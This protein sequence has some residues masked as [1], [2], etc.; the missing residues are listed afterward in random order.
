MN[1]FQKIVG[2]ILLL[3][4]I[5]SFIEQYNPTSP[6]INGLTNSVAAKKLDKQHEIQKVEEVLSDVKTKLK[7][8]MS[9]EVDFFVEEELKK[10]GE[11]GQLSSQIINIISD[12]LKTKY[13]DPSD[14][15][16]GTLVSSNS[17]QDAPI[18]YTDIPSHFNLDD[19]SIQY[20]SLSISPTPESEPKPRKSYNIDGQQFLNPCNPSEKFGFV[21]ANGSFDNYAPF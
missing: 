19:S 12:K 15:L 6:L 1:E 3:L 21:E 14:T 5:S 7:Q 17:V 8:E 20:K 13:F 16:H 9:D 18:L 10:A 4:I 11:N 2:S